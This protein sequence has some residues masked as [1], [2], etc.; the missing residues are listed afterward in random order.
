MGACLAPQGGWYEG[1]WSGGE[2]DGTGVRLMRNGSVKVGSPTRINGNGLSSVCRRRCCG[3]LHAIC[4]KE[5]ATILFRQIAARAPV[6][7]ALSRETHISGAR[8]AGRAV[9]QGQPGA[10][11]GRGG[12]C[13]TRQHGP[14][15]SCSGAEV[16]R[17]S[18]SCAP[19][20]S[21]VVKYRQHSAAFQQ[22]GRQ[23]VQAKNAGRTSTCCLVQGL[24]G[25]S[26]FLWRHCVAGIVLDGLRGSVHA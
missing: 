16:F 13:V 6:V 24:P 8:P 5:A 9:A 19:T 15:G 7:E 22:V 11:H 18:L 3:I 25:G 23:A 26:E 21:K 1:E 2:R 20:L 4:H 14:E 17:P 10:A 12:V